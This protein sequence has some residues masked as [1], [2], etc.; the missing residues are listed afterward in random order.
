VKR[1]LIIAAAALL[2]APVTALLLLSATPTL[3]LDP[4]LTSIGTATPVK[5]RVTDP[6]GVRNVS[7]WVEQNGARYQVLDNTRPATRLFF[8]KR[9]Q[10]EEVDFVAGTKTTPALKDGKAKLV[11]EASSNDLRGSTVSESRDVDIITRPP[12]ITPDG[13]QHY[14]NQGGT[15]LVTFSVSGFW[16]EAGEKSGAYTFRSFPLPGKQG[17]RFSL[18]AYPW[19][20]PVTTTP[21]VYATNPAGNMAIGHF[22]FKIFP[23]KFRKRDLDIDDAF[24][25]KVVDE[26]DPGGSGDLVSRFLKINGEMRRANNQTLADLRNKTEEKFLWSGPFLRMNAK[27][28][29][30]FA[31]DRT[32]IY[33]GKKIDEQVHLGFDLS[34]VKNT[35]IPAAN[36]GKVVWAERLGIYGNCIVVDHG[37]GLQSIYGHLNE[38]R[39]KPGDMVK[40]GQ[41]MGLSGATGLAGG[42]HL[43]FSMQVD[44]VQINPVEWWDEH[45][46]HD[47]I[48]SKVS[49]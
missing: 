45:W 20:L 6:H 24:L 23:K 25:N 14:I 1:I 47:R 15:E 48:L 34:N 8:F 5:I 29:S 39:V 17:Q 27:A 43:H 46:I 16:T 30:N 49:P 28:E 31:D 10:P 22:W 11:V 26:I 42:D 32:Y 18:F 33:H 12:S 36:D 19:D 13:A 3:A 38:I 35:P 40:K 4:A 7:A 9:Q 37:Y 2:I 44:G 41:I 21:F